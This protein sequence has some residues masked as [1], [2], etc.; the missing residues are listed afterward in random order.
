MEL[1]VWLDTDEQPEGFQICYTGFGQQEHAL[2]WKRQSGFVHYRVDTG[3]T[4]PDKNLTPILVTDGAVPWE[5]LRRDFFEVSEGV[6]AA[7]RQFVAARLAE[8]GR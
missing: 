7:L 8:G 1:I 6:D 2:T 4:R 3:D 5:R